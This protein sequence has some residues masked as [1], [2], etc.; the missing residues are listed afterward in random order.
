MSDA[1]QAEAAAL[2]R[3]RRKR[4]IRRGRY[5]KLRKYARNR[6]D[7]LLAEGMAQCCWCGRTMD[8]EDA[9]IEHIIPLSEGG[10]SNIANLALACS[11]CNGKRARRK[12]EVRKRQHW[13]H[14]PCPVCKAEPHNACRQPDGSVQP[15]PHEERWP[16]GVVS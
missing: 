7:E 3:G 12:D 2:Y 15:E 4:F 6:R 16:A 14:W 5:A 8:P 13:A 11:P 10:D 1:W 9:T